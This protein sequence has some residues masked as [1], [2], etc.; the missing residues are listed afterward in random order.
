MES[1][2]MELPECAYAMYPK[3]EDRAA[4]LYSNKKRSARNRV[5]GN[6]NVSFCE[7]AGPDFP[8]DHCSPCL[9]PY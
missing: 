4:V 8:A 5:C 3:E 6:G 7:P 1:L 2:N 9:T